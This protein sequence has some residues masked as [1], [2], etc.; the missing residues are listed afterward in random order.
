MSQRSEQFHRSAGKLAVV[1]LAAG[2]GRRFAS[3]LPKVLHKA[4]G[5]PLL[6]HVLNACGGLEDVDRTIVVVGREAELVGRLVEDVMQQAIVVHQ[7]ELLGTADALRRC[8]QAL[9][10]FEG[11]ILTLCGDAPLITTATLNRLVA[12]HRQA[13]SPVTLLSARVADPTGYGR[14]VRGEDGRCSAVVEE[15][16]ATPEQKLIDEVSSGVWCFAK[17]PLFDALDA[18]DNL[19]AQGEYYL[20]RAAAIIAAGHGSIA[21]VTATDPVEIEGVNDRKQLAAAAKVLWG[22]KVESLMLAGVSVEDPST[23]YIDSGVTVEPDSLIRPMTFLEGATRIGPGC[24]VGPCA[25]VVDSVLEKGAEVCF[26]V[27]RDCRIGPAASVGPFTSLRPGTGLG[28]GVRA[29]S[30]V[31]IKGSVIGEGSKVP[32]L[33]YVGDARVGAGVNLGA[34]TITANYDRETRVKSTT[35]IGDGAFTGSDTTLVAPVSL[36]KGSG[37]GAGSVVTRDVLEGQIVA[38]VPARPLRERKKNGLS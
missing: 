23:T 26:A 12:L 31:E 28:P 4:A 24:S 34:G 25:R 27:V 18:T 2:A 16:D 29:G 5:A 22:R 36:G 14:I 3:P 15:V 32:H 7:T 8:A 6:Q 38:G 9:E 37:T 10:D 13:V 30:F 17:Q 11:C 35:T 19:N 33:S 21:V 1:V 20:P